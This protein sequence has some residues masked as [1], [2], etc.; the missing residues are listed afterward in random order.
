MVQRSKKI[1]NNFNKSKVIA[2]YKELAGQS[3]DDCMTAWFEK[4]A[5]YTSF[6]ATQFTGKFLRCSDEDNHDEN[7]PGE[8]DCIFLVKHQTFQVLAGETRQ[9]AVDMDLNE[10]SNW[11]CSKDI[12]VYSIGEAHS[13]VKEYFKCPAVRK[14]QLKKIRH[15]N[16]VGF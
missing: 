3:R 15:H 16:C 12:F 1:S 6:G 5:D 7:I 13:R 9:V 8:E 2:A 4:A 10:I 11:G 14:I